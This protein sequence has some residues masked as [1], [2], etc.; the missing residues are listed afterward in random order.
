MPPIVVN[1]PLQR[2]LMS[3]R[4]FVNSNSRLTRVRRTP[5]PFINFNTPKASFGPLAYNPME[6]AFVSPRPHLTRN[7]SRK[8]LFNP[9]SRGTLT[10][11][12]PYVKKSAMFSNGSRPGNRINPFLPKSNISGT[13]NKTFGSAVVLP[14]N[15]ANTY[16]TGIYNRSYSSVKRKNRKTRRKN[17]N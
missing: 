14:T 3:P 2:A 1:N 16:S 6:H 9:K 8:N 7:Q 12:M 5:P 10:K 4:P 13:S 11:T 17:S 15:V